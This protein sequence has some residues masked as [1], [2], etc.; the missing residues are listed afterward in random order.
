LRRNGHLAQSFERKGADL[1]FNLEN[2]AFVPFYQL[3]RGEPYQM[4]FDLIG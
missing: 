2:I 4:Y 1:E 3:E